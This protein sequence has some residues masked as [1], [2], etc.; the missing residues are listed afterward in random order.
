M[1]SNFWALYLHAGGIRVSNINIFSMKN[2]TIM[3]DIEFNGLSKKNYIF[4]ALSK[5]ELINDFETAPGPL[6]FHIRTYNRY[7]ECYK[8]SKC[9]PPLDTFE[10]H[11]FEDLIEDTSKNIKS[12]IL[13]HYIPIKILNPTPGKNLSLAQTLQ[14][15]MIVDGK[16]WDPVNVVL[17]FLDLDSQTFIRQY[18]FDYLYNKPERRIQFKLLDYEIYSAPN[19]TDYETTE[20]NRYGKPIGTKT[21]TIYGSSSYIG[22]LIITQPNIEIGTDYELAAVFKR[23]LS[24]LK[25]DIKCILSIKKVSD[26][27][28]V[29]L[30]TTEHKYIDLIKTV[31][32]I[33]DK[34]LKT[35]FFYAII[36]HVIPIIYEDHADGVAHAAIGGSQS[37]NLKKSDKRIKINNQVRVVYVNKYKTEYVKYRGLFT[38]LKKVQKQMTKTNDP[39]PLATRR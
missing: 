13:K 32:D 34:R 1:G 11:Q 19:K 14:T 28:T 3:N 16:Y 21:T 18:Y 24:I 23:P 5:K 2:K 33:I 12:Y 25:K 30:T 22:R 26:N 4:N 7:I 6:K 17:K 20:H 15:T 27:V 9:D 35:D 29:S 39:C 36:K 31:S 38:T 8:N 37:A 10:G